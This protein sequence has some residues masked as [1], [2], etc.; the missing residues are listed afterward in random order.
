MRRKI[1][2]D[3]LFRIIPEVYIAEFDFAF[4]LSKLHR[5]GD[6]R[7]F[8]C[9][10]Q[11]LKHPFGCSSGLLQQVGDVCQLADRLVEGTH[12]LDEGLD[13][14]YC[15]GAPDGKPAPQDGNNNITDI[16]KEVHYRHH[17]A[18]KEL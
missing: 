13:V 5:V 9:L 3:D 16:A 4:H 11:E 12:I 7:H 15:D 8:F 2:D 18:R 1:L 17:D 10:V 6:L 14:A